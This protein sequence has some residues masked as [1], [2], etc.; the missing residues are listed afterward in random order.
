M[1]AELDELGANLNWMKVKCGVVGLTSMEEEGHKAVVRWLRG[2]LEVVGGESEAKMVE[3]M[4]GP[5]E[6]AWKIVP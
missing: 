6:G 1:E 5:R 4:D 2:T 3:D